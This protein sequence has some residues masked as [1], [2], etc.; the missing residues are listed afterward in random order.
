MHADAAAAHSARTAAAAAYTVGTDIVF[1]A[2]MYR[3]SSHAGQTLLA[4]ELVHVVQQQRPS[5][6]AT[7][8]AH[9]SEAN[10]AANQVMRGEKAPVSLAAPVSIQR[11]PL[12]GAV[13]DL[14]LTESASPLLASAIGSVTLDGFVTGKSDVSGANQAKLARRAETILK[15]LKR[16]PASTLH[17]IGYTDAVGQESDNQTLGQSRA[18]AVRA[19][20]HD[21][22]IPDIVMQ[23]DSRG[24]SDLVVTTTKAEARNRRVEV[25]FEVSTLLRGAMSQGLTLGQSGGTT[26]DTGG[27]GGGTDVGKICRVPE[28]VLRPW[29]QSSAKRRADPRQHAVQAHG[30]AGSRPPR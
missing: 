7:T 28:A 18:D 1:G 29:A 6:A 5:G 21:V 15:L 26:T 22:G 20:L 11:Q 30:P 16:Y 12:P 17:L 14:D 24:A 8:P 13:P 3:P 23:A 10:G 9:E 25:R 2:D 19:A 4:H 27:S